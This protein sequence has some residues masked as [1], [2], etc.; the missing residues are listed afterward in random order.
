[1][2][3][4]QASGFIILLAAVLF[5][6]ASLEKRTPFAVPLPNLFVRIDQER[7]TF[8]EVFV[9]YGSDREGWG[10]AEFDDRYIKYTLRLQ[11]DHI[12]R[13][14]PRL[15]YILTDLEAEHLNKIC[16]LFV[17]TL[18]IFEND[19][20]NG[21]WDRLLYLDASFPA[22]FKGFFYVVKAAYCSRDT[23]P[24]ATRISDTLFDETFDSPKSDRRIQTWRTT[25]EHITKLRIIA[26]ELI[27]QIR[28]W[29]KMELN[30]KKRQP[31]VINDKVRF[32]EAYELFIKM[33]FNMKL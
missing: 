21:Q 26:R 15:A 5:D 9:S 25:P 23:L 11:V 8:E 33:Y 19:L 22:F 16:N 12:Y 17:R 6:S 28:Q 27:Y 30:N 3:N 32:K 13:E 2:K 14:T 10:I 20:Q 18:T 29:Q 31:F 1:M 7:K 4:L 24:P